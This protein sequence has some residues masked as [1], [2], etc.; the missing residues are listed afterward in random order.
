MRLGFTLLTVASYFR[1]NTRDDDY[2]PV[3]YKD[4][5]QLIKLRAHQKIIYSGIIS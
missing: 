4:I 5:M 2:D 3:T 1:K